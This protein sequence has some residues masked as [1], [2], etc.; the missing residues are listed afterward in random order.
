[1]SSSPATSGLLVRSQVPYT[2]AAAGTR[3]TR[4]VRV[5]PVRFAPAV[6]GEEDHGFVAIVARAARRRG[7]CAYPGEGHNR[8]PAVH[9]SDAARLV[10]AGFLSADVP[11]TSTIARHL[12]RWGTPGR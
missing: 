4:G 9:R 12:A 7:A 1:M 5:L 10:R 3:T 2:I 8:R 6:H 11:A